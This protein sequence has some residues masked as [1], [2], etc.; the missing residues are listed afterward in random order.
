VAMPK[1]MV[2]NTRKISSNGGMAASSNSLMSAQTKAS[3][4][5][6]VGFCAAQ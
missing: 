2:P 4:F 1:N 5:S 3:L 6:P